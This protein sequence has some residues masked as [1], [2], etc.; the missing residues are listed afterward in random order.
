MPFLRFRLFPRLEEPLHE[1]GK[2]PSGFVLVE[3]LRAS[4]A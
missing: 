3:R 4:S 2:P 1:A